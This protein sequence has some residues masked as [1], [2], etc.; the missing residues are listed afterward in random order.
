MKPEKC[1]YVKGSKIKRPDS[2]CT[3]YVD[4]TAG[5]DFREGVD[6]ELSHWI[7]NR[8]EKRFKAGTSTEICFKFLKSQKTPSYDLVINN[9][10]DI[11]GLLSV[12]ALSYPTVSLQ[13]RDVLINTA[14][15]G[16]FWAWS[17]GKSL[18]LFQELTLLYRRL[19]TQKVDLQKAY[20]TCFE[21]ILKIL[22]LSEIIS[23]V[24]EML[25]K[26]ISLVKQGTIQRQEISHRLV[27][28]YVPKTL[29][30]KNVS[31]YLQVPHFNE[32]LSE[33][34]AF[35]PQVRN[36]LDEEKIQLL[37][38]ETDGGIHYSLWY[39]GYVWADTCN[40]WRPPGLLLSPSMK[41]PHLID[42]PEL[43][44]VIQELNEI[45]SGSCTWKL[46]PGLSFSGRENPSGFPVVA[47]TL[48]DKN[49]MKESQLI[50]SRVNQSFK[51]LF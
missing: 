37:A 20:E 18:T 8:T 30:N 12:F 50:L 51:K 6:I 16:D 44:H 10:L 26:Q 49:E 21:S 17:E 28:Y 19:E 15:A 32:P 34:V 47:V 36:R 1:F 7:P 31:S 3:I 46:F 22:K 14:K 38:I 5:A 35:W 13:Y 2:K 29:S 48:N 40:L 4:G 23:P 45:E 24:Q 25:E 9:H 39:P 41:D 27:T 33:R 42:W 11:D 43:S